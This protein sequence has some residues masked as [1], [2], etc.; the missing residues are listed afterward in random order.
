MEHRSGSAQELHDA[1]VDAGGRRVVVHRVAGP[2]LV[3]GSTQ[4][5]SVVDA[6]VAAAAGVEVARR[7]SGG[8]AVLLV[9]GA[10]VWVDVFVPADDPLWDHDVCRASWW[11]GEAWVAALGG[12]DVHRSGVTDRAA[13]RVAC[14]AAVGPGEVARSGA[15]VL[16]IS[17]RRT[18][19]GARFQC[20]AYR[21]W[22]GRDLLG[23]LHLSDL[24]PLV[25]SRV[26]VA[27]LDRTAAAVEPGWGV[28]ED[29]LPHLP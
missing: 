15:K 9:P 29:L 5:R 28:V 17:Q 7:R 20:V 14:F 25:R 6:D 3:L 16:G 23:L 21:S 24:D 1:P 11:L 22:D 26:T 19:L 18:R 12:G 4:D 13:A 2:A 8:G 27:L 10:H